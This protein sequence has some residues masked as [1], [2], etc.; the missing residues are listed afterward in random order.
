MDSIAPDPYMSEML[1]ESLHGGLDTTTAVIEWCIAYLAD[2]P[3]FQR[4]IHDEMDSICGV[5]GPTF[6]D[7]HNLTLLN[8]AM[9]ETLRM[10]QIS[11]VVV[12][13]K[14]T[15]SIPLGHDYPT[16]LRSY[17]ETRGCSGQTGSLSRILT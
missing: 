8:A 1:F 9:M 6:E 15:D 7:R 10:A 2:K 11:S 4:R 13:H 3:E 14:A 12:P 17:G 5:D 16:I